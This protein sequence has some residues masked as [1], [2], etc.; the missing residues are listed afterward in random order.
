M[1]PLVLPNRFPSA[2]SSHCRR[3]K[4]EKP[5][6]GC[7]SK[8]ALYESKGSRPIRCTAGLRLV[9]RVPSCAVAQ[10]KTPRSNSTEGRMRGF[11]LTRETYRS[12]EP[13][14]EGELPLVRVSAVV[15]SNGSSFPR[16][17]QKIMKSPPVPDALARLDFRF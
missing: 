15:S 4:N 16:I 2:S 5:H 6:S 12:S 17:A 13:L 9:M 11:I 7:A 1:R 3:L 14:E 8:H 10:T